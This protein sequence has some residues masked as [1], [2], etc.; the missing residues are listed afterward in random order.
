MAPLSLLRRAPKMR[1]AGKSVFPKRGGIG[2]R[3]SASRHAGRTSDGIL[4]ERMRSRIHLMAV[5]NGFP[6]KAGNEPQWASSGVSPRTSDGTAWLAIVFH[7][8]VQH[9]RESRLVVLLARFLERELRVR[10]E[11]LY[12]AIVLVFEHRSCCLDAFPDLD[13][14]CVHSSTLFFDY[15]GIRRLAQKQRARVQV[16]TS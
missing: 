11:H 10:D 4:D 7:E 3:D 16:F 6:G 8:V 15:D 14:D 9:T 2:G 13:L 12:G 1:C 5:Q